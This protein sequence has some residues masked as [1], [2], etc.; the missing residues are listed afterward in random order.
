MCPIRFHSHYQRTCR[1]C[2]Y[3]WVVSRAEAATS[4]PSD[5][6][7]H[8]YHETRVWTDVDGSV[9]PLRDAAAEQG[10]RL[11]EYE[12]TRRCPGCGVD[13][14]DER[15]VKSSRAED[16]V[17]PVH[18]EEPPV[19]ALSA[20]QTEFWNGSAWVPATLEDGSRW[21]GTH[22]VLPTRDTSA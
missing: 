22:W 11:E 4:Q 8:A 13:D 20:D 5:T 1:S 16:H 9:R 19:G 6:Q 3:T 10:A 7:V 15:P 17:E 2:G 21:D 18:A 14:F 12:Q